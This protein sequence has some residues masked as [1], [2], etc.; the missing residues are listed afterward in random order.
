MSVARSF[1]CRAGSAGQGLAGWNESFGRGMKS[2]EGYLAGEIERPAIGIW[3]AVSAVIY[4]V[5]KIGVQPNK[6]LAAD[7]LSRVFYR[8]TV[9]CW[10]HFWAA[11]AGR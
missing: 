8:K 3:G 1:N 10:R 6:P 9:Q 5:S 7:P 4:W 11:E 2:A